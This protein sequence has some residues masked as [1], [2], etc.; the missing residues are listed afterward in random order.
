MN[1]SRNLHKSVMSK[2]RGVFQSPPAGMSAYTVFGY[3]DLLDVQA[4]KKDV[5]STYPR[6]FLIEAYSRPAETTLPMVVVETQGDQQPF[7]LGSTKG[8]LWNCNVHVLAR[9]TGERKDF[10]DLIGQSVN[11]YVPMYNF[12]SGSVSFIENAVTVDGV[13][14]LREYALKRDELRQDAAID[15]WSVVEFQLLTT[16]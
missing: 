9:M 10:C 13:V 8:H 4:G 15:N 12:S 11:R 5:T 2:V 1:D 16:S 14:K 3:Q 7:Q 6:V